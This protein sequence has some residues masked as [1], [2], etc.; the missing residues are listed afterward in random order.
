M[1][2]YPPGSLEEVWRHIGLP[3]GREMSWPPCV[4]QMI[5]HLA[6]QLFLLLWCGSSNILS[7]AI[8]QICIVTFC[9]PMHHHIQPF[10]FFHR[11]VTFSPPSTPTM[12]KPCHCGKEKAHNCFNWVARSLIFTTNKTICNS[13]TKLRTC[14]RSSSFLWRSVPHNPVSIINSTICVFAY[15]NQY[16]S[17][18]PHC[19]SLI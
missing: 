4:F 17:G 3:T 12:P 7:N 15:I 1:M 6:V 16:D 18:K 11:N 5:K 9:M 2:K 10:L 14:C 19:P 8:K 13:A